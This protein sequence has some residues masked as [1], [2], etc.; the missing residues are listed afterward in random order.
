MN[1]PAVIVA[2]AAIVTAIVPLTESLILI[3]VPLPA[4]EVLVTVVALLKGVAFQLVSS[5]TL[6]T[7]IAPEVPTP[8]AIVGVHQKL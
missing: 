7:S 2:E 8:T 1:L 3:T 4:G 6:S 5:C